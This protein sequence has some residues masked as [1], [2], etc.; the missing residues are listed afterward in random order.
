LPYWTIWN[1]F[2]REAITATDAEWVGG[3]CEL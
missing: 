1:R 2:E 3:E